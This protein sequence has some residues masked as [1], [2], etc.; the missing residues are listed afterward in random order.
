VY[1]ENLSEVEVKSMQDV[2]HLL[3]KGAGNRRVA[4][5]H[6]NAESS[7]SHSVFAC[8]IESRVCKY[9]VLSLSL[10]LLSRILGFQN[11]FACPS[12]S[13]SAFDSL[14]HSGRTIP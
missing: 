5:T 9:I 11:I 8:T 2:V 10:S 7:R 1:V 3:L 12:S 6:M 14:L 13:R 4:A